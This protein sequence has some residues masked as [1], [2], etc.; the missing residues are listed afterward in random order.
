MKRVLCEIVCVL[1]VWVCFFYWPAGSFAMCHHW[2]WK[3]HPR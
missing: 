3:T 1:D 2:R